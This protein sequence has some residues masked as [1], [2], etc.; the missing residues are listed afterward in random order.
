[1]YKGCWDLC[2]RGPVAIQ[3]IIQ[4]TSQCKAP[5]KLSAY[6][7]STLADKFGTT[8]IV[9]CLEGDS[10]SEQ[11]SFITKFSMSTGPNNKSASPSCG[12]CEPE[13]NLIKILDWLFNNITWPAK[14][15]S[16]SGYWA[17]RAGEDWEGVWT[18]AVH[19]SGSLWVHVAGH[20]WEMGLRAMGNGSRSTHGWPV[21]FQ[22]IL[23]KFMR[24]N[25]EVLF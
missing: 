1:M 12:G 7:V 6:S 21:K 18:M 17:T 24:A 19:R 8:R 3:H 11:E 2:R 4:A 15:G 14:L 10:C 5:M 9:W 23:K 22:K 13:F 16:T 25:L 20:L